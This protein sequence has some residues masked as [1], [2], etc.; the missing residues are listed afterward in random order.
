MYSYLN[1]VISTSSRS[2]ICPGTF[3]HMVLVANKLGLEMGDTFS[4][5]LIVF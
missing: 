2:Q 1:T 5:E 4:H 3:E